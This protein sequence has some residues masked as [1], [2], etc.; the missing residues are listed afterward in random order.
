MTGSGARDNA[1]SGSCPL[2]GQAPRTALSP[3]LESALVMPC[4]KCYRSRDKGVP[5]Q[6][7]WEQ[8][9]VTKRGWVLKS[10]QEFASCSSQGFY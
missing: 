4:A 8:T 3:A 7:A 5:K 1:M 10:E 9:E 6:P 2:R